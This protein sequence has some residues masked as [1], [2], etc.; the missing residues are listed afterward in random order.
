MR[1]LPVLRRAEDAE[2]MLDGPVALRDLSRSLADVARLNT[3]FGGRLISVAHVTALLRALPA[4]RTATVVDVGTGSGDLPRALVRW[5]RRRGRRV[6]V[7]AIDRDRV[8]LGVARRLCARFPEIS[9]VQA[10]ASALPLGL[11]AV[12]VVISALTL[13]HLEPPAAVR[14]LAEMD[15]AAREGMVVNDLSR[16]RAAYGLVWLAT[17]AL[18]TT[19]ESRHDG[20]LSVLRAYTPAELRGLGARAGLSGLRIRRYPILARQCLVR[21]KPRPMPAS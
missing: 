18:T 4:D 2:E 16:S 13:H 6:R 3:L 10:D 19:R 9:F 11:G 8:V 21:V 7:V 1:C 20:P 14:A 17:R 12:D 15:R 5:A